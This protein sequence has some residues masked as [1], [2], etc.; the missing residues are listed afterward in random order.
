M[1]LSPAIILSSIPL[2]YIL[3]SSISNFN[4][5]RLSYMIYGDATLTGRT[6]IWDFANS[7]IAQR[8]FFGWGYQSFWQVGPDAPSVVDAPGFIKMMPNG[9]NGYYDTTLELGYIG[10]YL[11]VI[12]LL[13]TLHAIGR[14]VHR[15]ATR[16]WLLLS[17]ALYVLCFN[18]LE[19][20]W[21]RGFEFLWVIFLI[22]AAEIGRFWRPLPQKAHQLTV[23][24]IHVSSAPINL[25]RVDASKNS[26]LGHPNAT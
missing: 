13:A 8:P 19:S 18:C 1:R 16:A 12:F 22:V 5:D 6:L 3:L 24:G 17:L 2:F 9:H 14:V 20:L 23:P 11:F 26:Q 21:M 4:V 15:D 10:Y 7:E 25:R